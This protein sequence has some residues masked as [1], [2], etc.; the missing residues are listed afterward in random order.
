MKE[1]EESAAK[2]VDG[3]VGNKNIEEAKQAAR[4]QKGKESFE[5]WR[6]ENCAE[7]Q[8]VNQALKNG[9]DI[10]DI[11]LNTISFE[12]GKFKKMCKNCKETFKDFMV[13][14]W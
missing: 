10:E 2:K 4:E 11:L 1:L 13:D 12:T 9:A 6:V 14:K 8:A 3:L 5:K 7:I